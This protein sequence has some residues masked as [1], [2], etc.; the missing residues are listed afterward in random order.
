M[1]NNVPY[2]V[3]VQESKGNLELDVTTLTVVV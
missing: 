1:T 3:S 2:L